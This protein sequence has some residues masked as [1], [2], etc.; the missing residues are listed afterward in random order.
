MGT[1]YQ[2]DRTATND[3]IG[4]PEPERDPY[5]VIPVDAD[6]PNAST[7]QIGYKALADWIAWLVRPRSKS[8]AW[9]GSVRQYRSALGHTRFGIDHH[10]FPSGLI[11]S[12]SVEFASLE[13]LTA[14]QELIGDPA[15]LS[16]IVDSGA[17]TSEVR[18][19]AP[20]LT[21]FPNWRA[22]R[23]RVA[24]TIDDY[25]AVIRH[26]LCYLR[27]NNHVVFEGLILLP[28]ADPASVDTFFGFPSG[29]GVLS[30]STD[31]FWLVK[32]PGTNW[33]A[34]TRIGGVST[35]VDTGVAGST[36]WT[37]LRVEWHGSAVGESGGRC[38]FIINGSVVA[39]I[40]ANLPVDKI[41]VPTM[42][43]RQFAG[44]ASSD[45]WFWGPARVRANYF[46]SDVLI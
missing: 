33:F 24:D 12:D 14:S 3:P 4:A 30:A 22:A 20:D 36:S 43:I 27:S 34:Y 2:G 16:Q 17:G 11:L 7:F 25:A 5:A 28:S 15:W 38:V 6:P 13:T 9:N 44:A 10:G 29:T 40:T 42:G 18:T 35:A 26:P 31:G 21:S 41:A 1:N 37:R 39:N 23:M 46:G 19:F 45:L 8:T 32:Q